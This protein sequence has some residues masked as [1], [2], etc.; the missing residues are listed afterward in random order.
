MRKRITAFILAVLVLA[1]LL[2]VSAA[3][4][5]ESYEAEVRSAV[6]KMVKDY[7]QKVNQSDAADDAF[8]DFFYMPFLAQGRQKR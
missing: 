8:V 1:S 6:T 3:A 5:N 7:S 4:V 2:P